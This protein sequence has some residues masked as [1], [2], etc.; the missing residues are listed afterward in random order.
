M[1]TQLEVWNQ[2]L[3][4]CGSAGSIPGT[5]GVPDPN[6]KSREA[7]LCR[8]W[9]DEVVGVVQEGAWWPS[10][11]RVADL[12]GR[13]ELEDDEFQFAFD[14]PDDYLR[15]W[16]LKSGLPFY[17]TD[18][19]LTDDPEP[20]LVFSFNNT[21]PNTWPPAQARATTYGLA[22]KLARPLTG[23]RDL[24][25]TLEGQANYLLLEARAVEANKQQNTFDNI[26]DWIA[27]RQGGSSRVRYLHPVGAAFSSYS[28]GLA[29]L[30]QRAFPRARVF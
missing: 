13:D 14:L 25:T 30:E 6:D 9:Y 29:G 5:D 20:R 28:P 27:A 15:A 3:Q 18:K 8:T 7:E 1:P 23:H 10:S 19:F 24:A 2:A 17:I 22:S 26:P 21:D 4:I 11:R 16:Y 12:T